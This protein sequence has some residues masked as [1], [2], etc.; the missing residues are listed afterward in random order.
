MLMRLE[1]RSASLRADAAWPGPFEPVWLPSL[2][3]EGGDC[4]AGLEVHLTVQ[5]GQNFPIARQARVL[6]ASALLPVYPYRL[7]KAPYELSDPP[8]ISQMELVTA[9][10]WPVRASR[11]EAASVEAARTAAA[12]RRQSR[13]AKRLGRGWASSSCITTRAVKARLGWRG[14]DDVDGGR[15]VALEGAEGAEEDVAGRAPPHV[16]CRLR[17]RAQLA[18]QGPIVGCPQRRPQR[19]A[20]LQLIGFTSFTLQG[21]RLTSTLK[22]C[23]QKGQLEE[24]AWPKHFSRQARHSS[25]PQGSTCGDDQ[26]GMKS[27]L[28]FVPAY[29]KGTILLQ[30]DGAGFCKSWSRS[31]RRRGAHFSSSSN[32]S[33]WS[34]SC[35][36]SKKKEASSPRLGR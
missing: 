3:A 12:W 22:L 15:R 8:T 16:R 1:D 9:S 7:Q 23:L 32:E 19:H 24:E 29:P 11:E 26:V 17:L 35:T 6:P 13:V 30:A 34:L 25:W 2:S 21:A 4:E 31:G 28:W 33:F 18:L 10:M 5:Q 36:F 27:T 20:R 14:L